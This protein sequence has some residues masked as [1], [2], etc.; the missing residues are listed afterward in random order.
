MSVSVSVGGVSCGGGHM[1]HDAKKTHSTLN[2]TQETTIDVDDTR[3]SGAG[4]ES[5]WDSGVRG[6]RPAGPGAGLGDCP[7]RECADE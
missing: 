6:P 3:T 2:N 7:P 1:Q 4:G 5:D